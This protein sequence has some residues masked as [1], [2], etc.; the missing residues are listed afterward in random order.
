MKKYLLNCSSLKDDY[1]VDYTL[2]G[3]FDTKEAAYKYMED[4]NK[5]V[6]VFNKDNFSLIQEIMYD[7]VEDVQFKDY[8]IEIAEGLKNWDYDKLEA[9]K[10]IEA[11]IDDLNNRRDK[12][13]QVLNNKIVE[14]G[15]IR[16]E[17]SYEDSLKLF[18]FDLS[19]KDTYIDEFDGKPKCLCSY[20]E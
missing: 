11:K 16:Y 19:R 9:N 10:D 13:M 4:Y 5:R 20:S 15:I 6:E 7:P 3:I 12:K 17:S 1:S 18:K 14:E 8:V 2:V